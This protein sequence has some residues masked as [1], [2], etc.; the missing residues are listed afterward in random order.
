MAKM[1]FAPGEKVM[2]DKLTCMCNTCPRLILSKCNCGFA[3]RER[4]AIRVKLKL[5]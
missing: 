4:K 2:F 3:Q 1:L 5:R